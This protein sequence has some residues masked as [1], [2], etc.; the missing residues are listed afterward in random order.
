LVIMRPLSLPR[1]SALMPI[2]L[3]GSEQHS[4]W[5]ISLWTRYMWYSC[6][7]L[8]FRT[9]VRCY[10]QEWDITLSSSRSELWLSPACLLN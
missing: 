6:E 5:W 4:N 1:Q 8:Q 9:A 2:G 7:Y 3:Y 10:P